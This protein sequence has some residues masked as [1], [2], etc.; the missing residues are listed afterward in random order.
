MN[1]DPIDGSNSQS[2]GRYFRLGGHSLLAS[3]GTLFCFFSMYT[4][5]NVYIPI[6]LFSY[7]LNIFASTYFVCLLADLSESL[8]M[9]DLVDMYLNNENQKADR[10]QDI[11]RNRAKSNGGRDFYESNVN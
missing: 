10:S 7:L 1:D 11:S 3:I 8:L 2:V 5:G 4:N 6:V 9:W